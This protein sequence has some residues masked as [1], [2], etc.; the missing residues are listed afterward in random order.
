MSTSIIFATVAGMVIGSLVFYLIISYRNWKTNIKSAPQDLFDRKA[1][2]DLLTR[3]GFKILSVNLKQPVITNIDGK[4]HYGHVVA[5]YLV[6]KGKVKYIVIV[7]KGEAEFDANDPL[8]RRRLIECCRVFNTPEVLLV[9]PNDG[10][11][12]VV[13][14]RYPHEWSLDFFFRF[15]LA[16]FIVL[17]LIG[18]IWLLASIGLL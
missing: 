10:E 5:D 1:T 3:S 11:I 4:E 6:K 14:F 17:G 16:G 15:L 7:K 8:F 12:H 18:I 13:G 2:E 9:D